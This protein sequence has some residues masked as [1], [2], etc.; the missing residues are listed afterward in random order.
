MSYSKRETKFK[1]EK[2]N[3]PLYIL[4][5]QAQPQTDFHPEASYSYNNPQL[6]HLIKVWGSFPGLRPMHSVSFTPIL[7]HSISL[8]DI[9]ILFHNPSWYQSIYI[10]ICNR[11]QKIQQTDISKIL[12]KDYSP[13]PSQSDHKRIPSYLTYIQSPPLDCSMLQCIA[14]PQQNNST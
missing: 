6:W 3:F 11:L 14:F 9:Q 7:H 13:Y 5:L 8:P 4:K 2:T 1:K 12:F 10:Y